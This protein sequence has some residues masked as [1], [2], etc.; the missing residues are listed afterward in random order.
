MGRPEELRLEIFCKRDGKCHLCAG[1]I[2]F[3]NYGQYTAT[4]WQIDHV[5]PKAR[6]GSDHPDN[7]EPAHSD[8]NNYKGTRSAIVVRR[9]LMFEPE[10]EL[11]GGSGGAI[12]LCTAG[13]AAL[14][15]ALDPKDPVRGAV[16]G[17]FACLF[18]AALASS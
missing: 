18:L 2:R 3:E 13:S 1:K 5:V 11:R 4:G 10:P 9:E 12:L 17:G 8:C 16:I 14:G 7:L 15:A 6:G